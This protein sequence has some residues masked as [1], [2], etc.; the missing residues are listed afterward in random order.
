MASHLRPRR[1]ENIYIAIVCALPREYDAA[2]LA[3]DDVW[4]DSENTY[5][6]HCSHKIGRIGAHNVVLVLLPNP[7]K[8]SAANET[9]HL[10]SIYTNLELAILIGVCGGVPSP[11]TDKEILLGDVVISKSVVQY[12]LGRQYPGRFAT[13]DDV[14]NTLSRP[15][16]DIRAL[17]SRLETVDGLRDLQRQ[18]IQHLDQLKQMAAKLSYRACYDRPAASEDIL[19]EP[20]YTHRHRK[21]LDC[22]CNE[23]NICD[24]AVNASCEELQCDASRQIGRKRLGL[25]RKR[26]FDE[27]VNINNV[28]ELQIHVGRFGSGDTVVKSGEHRDEIA[29]EHGIIAFE[30]EGA[31]IW[32]EMPCIIVKSVCDYAD[33]H[34]NKRWQN[35]AAAVAASAAKALLG[36]YTRRASSRTTDTYFLVPYNENPDFVGRSE[37]L[38]RIKGYFGHE[39][40][41]AMIALAY[42]YWLKEFRPDISVFW[43]HASNEQRFRQAYTHIAEELEIP[44][45][46]EPQFDALL[47]VKSWLEKKERGQWLMV[48]DN[49]DDSHLFFQ[50][51]RDYHAGVSTDESGAECSLA[52]YIPECSHGSVLITTRNK[53]TGMRL[54]PPKPPI[55]VERMTEGEADQLL[56]SL[57]EEED[58]PVSTKDASHLSSRL[59][60]LPLA[61]AQA[62]A[63]IHGNGITVHDYIGLLNESDS[64]LVDFLSEPFEAVGRD[65]ATPHALTATW[66]ISFEQIERQ[67][68]LASNVLSFMSFLDRQA[69]PKRFVAEYLQKQPCRINSSADAT[70]EKV[71]GIL[72]AFS[73][74]TEAKNKTVDMHRLVQLITRKWL[75]KNYRKDEFAQQALQ[76]VST[77]FP[78]GQYENREV[79]Q[80]QLPHAYAVLEN[81][82]TTWHDENHSFKAARASLLHCVAGYLDYLGCWEECGRRVAEAVELRR[83]VLG[84]GHPST[85]NSVNDLASAYLRL[86]QFQEAEKLQSS[87]V[88]TSIRVLGDEHPDTLNRIATLAVIIR[89][90][91]RWKEAEEKEVPIMQIS[92]RVL[93]KDHPDTLN[94]IA[95]LAA[96]LWNMGRWKEAEELEVP[97]VAT[98]LRV[99]GAEHPNTLNRIANLAVTIGSQGRW[100]EAEEKELQV[101]EISLRVLGE[102]H[103]DTLRRKANLAVSYRNQGRW[104]EAEEIQ[105]EELEICSRV[106]G[107]EHP[108]TLVSMANLA[109]TYS[110]LGRWKEAEDLQAA[111]LKICTRVLGE[112]HPDTFVST[113]NL[114]SIWKGQASLALP[115]PTSTEPLTVTA[116][117]HRIYLLH[118]PS[119]AAAELAPARPN[120]DGTTTLVLRVSGPHLPRIK[121]ENEIAIMKWAREHTSVPVPAVIRWDSSCENVLGNEFSLLEKVPGISADKLF[122]DMS[123]EIRRKVVEQLVLFL[124]EIYK[125]STWKYVGGMKVDEK[126][127]I[128]PGPLVDEWFWMAP[129]IERFWG[130]KGE[131]VESLNPIDGPFEDWAAHIDAAMEKYVYVINHHP[132]LEWMRDLVP[133][134]EAFRKYIREHKQ[135]MNETRYVLAHRDLH[136][137]NIMVDKDGT[138]TG[139]LDWEFGG[140]VPGQRWDPPNAFLYPWGG[141][142]DEARNERDRMRG[143]AREFCRVKGIDEEVVNGVEYRGVQE[144]VHTISNYT[145]AICELW[146]EHRENAREWRKTLEGGLNKLGV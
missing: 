48:V 94:R 15:N 7:G 114:A 61:L 78:Y 26:K 19:F 64:T 36:R 135:E 1:L 120:T 126:G 39:Q 79:C 132:S 60:G 111:E 67:D 54:A 18:T 38:R 44:G 89:H 88:E 65:S 125:N 8:V 146:R 5:G 143:W 144:T 62:A 109:L 73:F 57:L 20:G 81:E 52:R 115:T 74:I 98:S 4:S 131:T 31:G 33:S 75:L 128:G 17:L 12:D 116:A 129:Q 3:F 93:G 51:Q 59:E 22:G 77:A 113:T 24:D 95:S 34:K 16:R 72:K 45:H 85:L 49:A 145:R 80:E 119:S 53:Q 110:C 137:A 69:I 141:K 134:L 70:V 138:V 122:W 40:Q 108:D 32:D 29:R 43:V 139:L 2:S 133:R 117:F 86:G 55:P 140:V 6:R 82:G 41:H 130:D 10:R 121:T 84:E 142:D 105:V 123:D 68:A 99:F 87:L 118:F 90:Q 27:E 58:C 102:E 28:E 14:D 107:K 47:L 103:P 104:M 63:F 56:R 9:S 13:K 37:A 97:L 25:Q 92:S 42:V 50:S 66:I 76:T 124:A 46:G 83:T 112:N 21:Q 106:L 23:T 35:F 101:L 100:K 30:M 136:L 96:T 127:E 91:G 11:G 71:L